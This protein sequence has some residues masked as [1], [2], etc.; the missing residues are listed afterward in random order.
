MPQPKSPHAAAK[1]WGGHIHKHFEKVVGRVNFM[2]RVF[3]TTETRKCGT[4]CLGHGLVTYPQVNVP[5]GEAGA[6][7]P[8]CVPALPGGSGCESTLLQPE[9]WPAGRAARSKES[10]GWSWAGVRG[11]ASQGGGRGPEPA[12]VSR[13][14]GGRVTPTGEAPRSP[15][16]GRSG[17]GSRTLCLETAFREKTPGGGQT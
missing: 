8:A 13:R 4:H 17:W 11:R 10:P 6:G 14:R 12:R 9:G 16:L 5:S 7:T 3:T 15:E 1:A 2:P